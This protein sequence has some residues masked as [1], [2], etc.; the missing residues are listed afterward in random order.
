ML[1]PM[2][3]CSPAWMMKFCNTCKPPASGSS[4]RSMCFFV[5]FAYGFSDIV[6]VSVRTVAR[7]S[8]SL[9]LALG[10]S[11]NASR[12]SASFTR[13]TLQ[14]GR[15]LHLEPLLQ[16]PPSLRPL[17]SR[18]RT[19]QGK[20]LLLSSSSH[21]LQVQELQ[22]VLTAAKVDHLLKVRSYMEAFPA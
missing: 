9:F 3:Y 15:W 8:R 10:T 2:I 11:L 22:E 5:S 20:P 18:H 12:C 7:I 19:G 21:T 1:G 17:H 4:T 16:R 14:A 13:R 6:L